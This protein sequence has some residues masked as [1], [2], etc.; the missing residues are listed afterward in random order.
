MFDEVRICALGSIDEAVLEL[1]PGLTVL[2]GETGAGKSS[3]VRAFGLL[4]GGRADA[5]HIRSGRASCAVEARLTVDPEGPVAAQ[6]RDAGGELE[7]STLL[8]ARTVSADGRSRAFIGGRAVPAG[9][10]AELIGGMLALHGQSSQL[11]LRHPGAQRAALDRFAGAAVL[12][13]LA[14][15]HA[16][17]D[18][19][20]QARRTLAELEAL[21]SERLREVELLKLGLAEVERVAPTAGE[22]L[23]LQRE[24]SRLGAA[25]ELRCA[26]ETARAALAGPSDSAASDDAGVLSALAFAVRA[27]DGAADSDPELGSLAVRVHEVSVLASELA[28]DLSSYA[29][30]VDDDPRR[31]SLAQERRA[32]LNR[33]CRPHSTDVD[34][35]LRWAQEAARRLFELDAGGERSSELR[36]TAQQ[37]AAEMLALAD[38]LSAE[39]VK[40]AASLQRRV[41]AELAALSM[42]AARLE[43]AVTTTGNG[44]AEAL[45]ADG[46]DEVELRFSPGDEMPLRP[47][48]R[49]ASGGEL[50]RVVLA[51]E[52]VLA[53]GLG[54]SSMIFDEV[55]AGIGGEAALEVGRRLQVLGQSRQVI[56]VTHLPQVAA[57]ADRHLLV[58]KSGTGA[59]VHSGVQMLEHADRVRE[60]SRMLAGVSDSELARGHAAELLAAATR[61]SAAPDVSV[62]EPRPR[63]RQP[64][65]PVK[66]VRRTGKLSV[67]A[68]KIDDVPVGSG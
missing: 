38:R 63:R 42:T 33:L 58:S 37:A 55:D 11:Q 28:A 49:S 31:L 2:S 40:A 68:P 24:L 19:W 62:A 36:A 12:D 45:G 18:R 43:V 39:R 23:E 16:A 66:V 48:A 54:P 7:G 59:D 13:Q 3:V 64:S 41:T 57:F 46:A 10:L 26:S 6:V 51:L 53:A 44:S 20:A 25:D 56:C 14:S 5:G 21:E 35:V 30:G 50:S 1:H 65:R 61:V 4:A 47:L 67:R 60:L 52:V 32:E 22:D 15:F 9:L 27:L 29:A 34:G 17:R 8:V